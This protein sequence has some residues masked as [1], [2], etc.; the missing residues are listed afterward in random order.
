MTFTPPGLGELEA[1]RERL[2][3]RVRTTPVW[4]WSGHHLAGALGRED[5]EVWLKLELFQFAGTFKPRGALLNLLA[6]DPTVLESGVTAVSAGNHAL[7]VAFA[8]RRLRTHAKVVMIESANPA[9]IEGCRALG[10]EVVLA[11]DVHT[12][13][14]EVRRIEAE[15]GRAFVHPFEGRET[16]LGTSGV[17]LELARSV[18]DLDAVV[19]PIGGGGLAAGVANAVKE[20]QPRCEVWGVEPEGADTMHRSFEAGSPQSID[21]VATIA[22]SL[23]APHAAPYTFALCRH[24]LDGLVKVSDEALVRSMRLLF[25]EMKLAVEPA[26][27]ATTAALLG[28]LAERLGG[29][30]VGLVVCGSNIDPATHARLLASVD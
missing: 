18:P 26:G 21:Q 13:F 27:A 28:P 5:G 20:S 6:L 25:D 16:A 22:D 15:E 14:E 30:K 19:V 24:Y 29:K 11:A 1:A 3:D 7:A 8:A 17:G 10:A 4:R 23:G 12:A 2:G 9:R